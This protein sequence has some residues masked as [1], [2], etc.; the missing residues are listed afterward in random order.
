V[1][2]FSGGIAPLLL[3]WKPSCRC[4]PLTSRWRLL[5]RLDAGRQPRGLPIF[6]GGSCETGESRNFTVHLL[7]GPIDEL[8]EVSSLFSTVSSLGR[9][10]L[11]GA[12]KVHAGVI[13]FGWRPLILDG[14]VENRPFTSFDRG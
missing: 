3:Q 10:L 6:L 12:L 4:I 14:E 2:G 5:G 8:G 11:F 1:S 9:F 13:Y 7:F